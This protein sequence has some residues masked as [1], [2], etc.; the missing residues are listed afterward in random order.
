MLTI[1]TKRTPE[2]IAHFHSQENLGLA[3]FNDIMPEWFATEDLPKLKILFKRVGKEAGGPVDAA[4]DCFKRD[5]PYVEDSRIEPIGKKDREFAYPSGHSTRGTLYALFLAEIEPDKSDALIERGREIGWNRVI[6][7]MHHPSDIAAGRV[8]GRA[9]ARALFR[10]ED[11]L[12][13]LE[14]VKQEYKA[15]REKHSAAVPAH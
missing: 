15:A 10:S 5:R 13:E 6:G 7:G 3:A 2:Q 11:F 9:I 4:K 12:T 14:R 1:Q 8:L